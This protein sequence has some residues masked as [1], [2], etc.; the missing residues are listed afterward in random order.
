M[1]NSTTSG[2]GGILARPASADPPNKCSLRQYAERRH[3][4]FHPASFLVKPATPP[5]LL[6]D[7]G[8]K[9]NKRA[10]IA[11]VRIMRFPA[12]IDFR[13]WRRYVGRNHSHLGSLNYS[14]VR[15][16]VLRLFR[17]PMSLPSAGKSLRSHRAKTAPV[18]FKQQPYTRNLP[19]HVGAAP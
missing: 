17:C 14:L 15:T 10:Q 11:S 6:D 13:S 4:V 3:T 1:R 9:V 5:L 18:I 16:C 19:L 7:Y 2:W 8:V 12:N